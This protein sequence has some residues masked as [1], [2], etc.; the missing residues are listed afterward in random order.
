MPGACRCLATSHAAR[1]PGR[2]LTIAGLDPREWTR[3]AAVVY[4][5]QVTNDFTDPVGAACHKQ[6]HCMGC[7]DGNQAGQNMTRANP[8]STIVGTSPNETD[9]S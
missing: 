3:S 1:H 9:T 7:G 5:T 2:G 8:G 4:E 6:L